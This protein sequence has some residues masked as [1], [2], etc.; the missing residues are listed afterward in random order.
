MTDFVVSTD[1][2]VLGMSFFEG[3]QTFDGQTIIDVDDTE[4]FLVRKDGDAGDVFIIDTVNETV[5]VS[6]SDQTGFPPDTRTVLID[7]AARKVTIFGTQS[8]FLLEGRTANTGFAPAASFTNDIGGADRGSSIEL[9]ITTFPMAAIGGAMLGST[10]EGYMRLDSRTGGV[11]SEKVR[12]NPDGATV[13]GLQLTSPIDAI[14]LDSADLVGDGVR[15][16]HSILFTAKGFDSENG[17]PHDVD[18]KMFV[19]AALDTGQRSKLTVQARID[20]AGFADIMTLQH[21]TT[22]GGSSQ[23]ELP[24]PGTPFVIQCGTEVD[25]VAE[26]NVPLN[27]STNFSRRFTVLG[28]GSILFRA[29]GPHVFGGTSTSD[30]VQFLYTGSFTSGGGS[31]FATGALFASDITSADGDAALS[32][33]RMGGQ[34]GGSLTTPGVGQSVGVATLLLDEPNLTIGGGDSVAIASTL[35]ISGA[36]TEGSSNNYGIFNSASM[37]TDGVADFFGNITQPGGSAS[38]TFGSGVPQTHARMTFLASFVSS[39]ASNHAELIFL[40]GSVTGFNADTLSLAALLADTSITTQGA[41]NTIADVAQVIIQEPNITIGAGDTVTNAQSLLI[42]GAPTEGV[43]NYALRVTSGLSQFGGNVAIGSA[44]AQSGAVRLT[45]L[46]G[47]S[48]R[49][50]GEDFDVRLIHLD[51][52]GAIEIGEDNFDILLTG[53]TVDM[54]IAFVVIGNSSTSPKNLLQLS[55]AQLQT[56]GTRN[57]HSF[58]VRGRSNDGNG[59]GEHT[60]E[61]K[62]FIDVTS[63]AGASTWTLQSRVDN[64]G[65]ANRITITDA[66]NVTFG[67]NLVVSGA[68]PHAIAGA[69]FGAVQL[70]IGD[71]FTSDGASNIASGLFHTPTIV[72]APGDT[73]ALTGT[74]LTAGITTQTATESIADIAQLQ[75]NEPF[76]TDNLTGDITN[77]QTL[78]ITGAPT[79][80]LSN[81]AIRVISGSVFFGG[82]LDVSG[83]TTTVGRIKTVT[84]QTTTYTILVTDSVVFGNTDSAGFTATLPAGVSGQTF[85]VI[86]SGSSGNIL[87]VTPDG[88]EDLLGVNS[89]FSLFDGEALDITFDSTDGWY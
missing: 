45:D 40:G 74:T 63:N 59:F 18:W 71:T 72:G 80:G 7:T 44:P 49:A 36:P 29:A 65:F 12:I 43:N 11:L 23:M 30:F 19:D 58:L 46:E 21:L 78:L 87:T 32:H 55:I 28:N 81:F 27:L 69:P 41:S 6:G 37:R 5:V 83:T 3:G 20:G 75:L 67:G 35:Q 60:I 2:I 39:G 48:A 38:I 56:P 34:G 62:S 1:L 31:N 73:A 89:S 26:A 22:G 53:D 77:A 52:N 68:G 84:R 66:G 86:N 13:H 57:S 61:W 24:G 9:G 85:K 4:A 82:S 25:I 51:S 64:A 42:V 76:I 17:G 16:S 10:A 14:V 79:E 33:V 50:D 15:D 47:V 70:L 54:P 88:S 8:G